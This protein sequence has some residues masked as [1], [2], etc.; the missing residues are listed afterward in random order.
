MKPKQLED[1]PWHEQDA[2]WKT[3]APVL[4]VQRRW[5][6]APAEVE[7][8]VS[9]LGIEPEA[10]ILDLCCGVGRHSLELARREGMSGDNV[11]FHVLLDGRDTAPTSGIGYVRRLAQEMQ[12]AGVGRIGTVVGRYYAM[13]R[14]K[15][16]ERVAKGYHLWTMAAGEVYDTAEAAV[17]SGYDNK[18]ENET[19]EFMKPKVVPGQDGPEGCTMRDGDSLIFL[20]ART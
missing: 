20:S 7:Q 12:R 4:F 13:D 15:R 14:D 2:F 8:V 3:V 19:D 5:A 10:Q 6:D 16:W 9:L 11:V 18:A 1:L 17:Q